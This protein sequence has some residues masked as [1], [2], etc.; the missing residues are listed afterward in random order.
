[1]K[2][3][4]ETFNSPFVSSVHWRLLF[5]ERK[6]FLTGET[7]NTNGIICSFKKRQKY[8]L[9]FYFDVTGRRK[10]E[11]DACWMCYLKVNGSANLKTS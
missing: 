11:E 4:I 7:G 3:C 1:M 9:I 2:F 6:D 8:V 10:E 5:K